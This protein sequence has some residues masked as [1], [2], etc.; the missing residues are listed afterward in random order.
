MQY[1]TKIAVYVILIR[2][3]QTLKAARALQNKI[4]TH[5]KPNKH[6]FCIYIVRALS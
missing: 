3:K 2:K 5:L 6:I 1:R 4:I